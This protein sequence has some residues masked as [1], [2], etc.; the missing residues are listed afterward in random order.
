MTFLLLA[1][2]FGVQDI[3]E[4]R[5]PEV[6]Y[7]ESGSAGD[8]LRI[9]LQEDGIALVNGE[10]LTIG[11]PEFAQ[12]VSCCAVVFEVDASVTLDVLVEGWDAV[13][14]AGGTTAGILVETKQSGNSHGS[15]K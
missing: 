13:V 7:V 9:R 12:R 11:G 10:R 4:V 2:R 15:R 3:S 14:G 8:A 1:A 5:L 6:R